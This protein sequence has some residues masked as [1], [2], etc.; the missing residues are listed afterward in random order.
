MKE[1]LVG[2]DFGTTN[3]VITYFENN[4][5]H[6]L[7]D[8][9][10][11]T[12][13]SKICFID[14]KIYCGNYIPIVNNNI[15][16]SFKLLED[17]TK[18][19]LIFF[20]HIN[21]IIKKN[22]NPDLIKAVI[23][24]PSKFNDI[25]RE[26]IKQCFEK[27][28][29]NVIRIINE[30]SAAAL[31][32]GLNNL[33]KNSDSEQILVIDIGGGTT[34]ITVLEKNDTL[35]EVLYNDGL[36]D[37][38]GN[39]FTQVIVD[40]N[41]NIFW[42]DN[43]KNIFWA[44]AQTVKEKL[45]YL[46]SYTVSKYDYS[47]SRNTFERLSS[48]LLSKITN[49]LN[50]IV[51]KYKN[52]N[53]IIMVGGTSRIPAIQRIVKQI[54]NKNIWIHD[55]LETVVSEGACLYCAILENKYQATN[56]ILFLDTLS[57][58]LG[59]ELSDGSYSIVVPKN[60]PL[61]IK[62]TQKYTTDTPNNNS[63]K[64]KVYQGERTIANKNF[65]IGEFIFDKISLG[66]VPIIDITFKID[67]NS[68]INIIVS[69]RKSGLEKSILIKDLPNINTDEI[70]LNA[71][72]NYKE[73]QEELLK[74]KHIYLIKNHIEN[75]LIN[76]NINDLISSEE[77]SKIIDE[78]NIIENKIENLNNI[79]L[80]EIYN[81]LQEKYNILGT[82][83]INNDISDNNLEID[84]LLIQDTKNK[85]ISKINLLIVKNP[86]YEEYL[87]PILENLSY[88]STTIEYINEKLELIEE[89][90]KEDGQTFKEQV[91]NLCIYLKLQIENDGLNIN[92]SQKELLIN[93][94][95]NT[96]NDLCISN[97]N[98]D[99]YWNNILSEFNKS[100]ENIYLL[101]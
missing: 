82:N 60:T 47:L 66:G 6:I 37:V 57:L 26:I 71:S 36:L 7:K 74:I 101:S 94:I 5:V 20:E 24:V 23:T 58:S 4:K 56:D 21:W 39:N 67:Y 97:N 42:A 65:L 95:H 72:N 55:N 90:E 28:N 3:T 46:D 85:L 51:S 62:I 91:N 50:D 31:C 2:I 1:I 89:L 68:I 70:L 59:I 86:E 14:D 43:D 92:S 77:K 84:N 45:T 33:N 12:I 53:Y 64:I 96:L 10:F 83:T 69:D 81:L 98:D 63:V 9:I 79:E 35:F 38:G 48:V 25:Q 22:L 32:Y 78:L 99:D 88:S 15:I 61:P 11:K 30:P 34:D 8:T 16:H 13:P 93:L 54:T 40:D 19:L 18:Y 75:C 100:C 27:N 76:L 73:D 49:I 87:N 29:I 80:I 44:T 52:I 17:N 41:K